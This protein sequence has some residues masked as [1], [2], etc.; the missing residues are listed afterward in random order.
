MSEAGSVQLIRVTSVSSATSA[1]NRNDRGNILPQM[2]TNCVDQRENPS[3]PTPL[4]EA[5]E[6][7]RGEI[8]FRV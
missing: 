3:P 6:A 2:R 4:P 8:Q 1:E 7:G 5:A